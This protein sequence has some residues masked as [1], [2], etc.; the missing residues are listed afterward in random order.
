MEVPA[1]LWEERIDSCTCSIIALVGECMHS[2]LVGQWTDDITRV[3]RDP[4]IG[5]FSGAFSRIV[6]RL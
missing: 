2:A 1:R 4:L 3:H 5:R 6:L